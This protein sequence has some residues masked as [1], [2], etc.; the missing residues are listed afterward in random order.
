MHKKYIFYQISLHFRTSVPRGLPSCHC[1]QP[2]IQMMSLVDVITCFFFC[3]KILSMLIWQPTYRT[4]HGTTSPCV[5][6]L[7]YPMYTHHATSVTHEPHVVI[8]LQSL[9]YPS[10]H[11]CYTQAPCCGGPPISEVS[12]MSP[13]YHMGHILWWYIPQSNSQAVHNTNVKPSVKCQPK[14]PV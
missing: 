5:L 3:H 11:Q 10:C 7:Q 1:E 8:I 2:V 13:V 12:L 14:Q 4:I 9:M 6:I